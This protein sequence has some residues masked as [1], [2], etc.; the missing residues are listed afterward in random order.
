MLLFLAL[1]KGQPAVSIQFEK[2][3]TVALK[4]FEKVA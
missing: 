4:S 1:G 2:N 3:T